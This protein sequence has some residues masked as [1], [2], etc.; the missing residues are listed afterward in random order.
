MHD[1]VPGHVSTAVGMND[2]VTSDET[3]VTPE[4]LR[5]PTKYGPPVPG[6]PVTERLV[7][8]TLWV[9]EAAVRNPAEIDDEL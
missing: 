8:K 4:A 1:I 2:M 5:T 9:T 7:S 6:N 3:I